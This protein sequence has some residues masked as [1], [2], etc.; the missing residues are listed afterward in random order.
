MSNEPAD[1]G[2]RTKRCFVVMGFGVKSDFA[3]GRT[4]D[5]D[6]SYRLL[7]KPVVEEK[8]LTCVRADEIRHSGS[9]DVIMY[10][11]LLMA[12]VVIADLSTANPNALYE[13]GIRH[14]LKPRTTIVISENKLPYPFDLNHIL[15]SSYAHLGDAIDYDEVVR[16][17]KILGD[18]L[19]A[20]LTQERTD[21]PVYTY[22]NDLTPPALPE[23]IKQAKAQVEQVM[24]QAA[25]Q[26]GEIVK[27]TGAEPSP[28]DPTLATLIQQGERAMRNDQFLKAR[29]IFELALQIYKESAGGKVSEQAHREDSYLLQRLAFA[30][31]KA[32]DPDEITGLYEALELLTT[33]LNLDDSNDPATVSLAGAI[34]KRLFENNQG[35]DHLNLA[36]WYY[37]RG[38]YLRNDRY[39]GINLAFLM[40]VRTDS[41]LDLKD[42]EKIADLVFANRIRN[43][44]LG[45]CEAELAAMDQQSAQAPESEPDKLQKEHNERQQEQRFWCLAT[46]AEAHLGLGEI[47]DYQ[48]TR[49]EIQSMAPAQWMQDTFE[50][51]VTR[52]RELMESHGH[53]LDPPWRGR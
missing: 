52:L 36:I 1:A 39:N 17:R 12:D 27:A 42:T 7:I 29:G 53:L 31:Y 50:K 24:Q 15:I 45:L 43:E 38:Y 22:L 4:L 32:E 46:K 23:D 14:A 33:R 11:E 48:S 20:V 30:T 16:F 5:L 37:G 13:L 49:A 8:G 2:A 34:E 41:I 18:N 10:Q 26:V 44:V 47:K 28:G 3:T 51:Q 19:D 21:S 35:A 40:N 25:E 6:K 9:I